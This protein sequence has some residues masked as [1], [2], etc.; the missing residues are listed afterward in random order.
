MRFSSQPMSL[1]FD[2]EGLAGLHLAEIVE[3][4]LGGEEGLAS[5]AIGFVIADIA[6]EGI[7]RVAEGQEIIGVRHVAVVVDPGGLDDA[8]MER[9]RGSDLGTLGPA[10]HALA[11]GLFLARQDKTGADADAA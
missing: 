4:R 8:A 10:R 11:C 2:G 9:D 5:G 3:M 1:R 6:E 7:E